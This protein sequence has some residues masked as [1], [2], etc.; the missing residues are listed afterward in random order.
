M[1][2]HSEDKIIR[3]ISGVMN[4]QEE[5]AFLKEIK[6]SKELTSMHQTYLEVWE[7]T[8]QLNYSQ[9]DSDLSWNQ[10]SSRIKAPI[11]LLGLDWRKLAAS[12]ILLAAFSFG[13]WFFGSTQVN[14]VTLDSVQVH[15]LAD[16]TSVKLNRNSSLKYKKEELKGDER[17]VFLTGE[18]YFD[19]ASSDKKFRVKTTY[20]DIVV[21]GTQFSLMASENIFYVE[22]YE[23]SISYEKEDQKIDLLPNERLILSHDRFLKEEFAKPVSWTEGISCNNTPLSYVLNQLQLTY[24]VNYE[25]DKKLQSEKYT[26]NLPIDDI[27]M[28]IKILRNVSGQNFALIDNI[29]LVKD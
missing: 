7:Q 5:E 1:S 19:V 9:D 3:L 21:H 28:C 18:A 29:I 27:E 22:L 15:N 24:G 23:G 6:H 26:L 8:S 12:I 20:G 25:I 17:T 16:N 4:L 14:L 11:K 2:L 10:F 13:M